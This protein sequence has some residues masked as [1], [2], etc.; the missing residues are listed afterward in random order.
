MHTDENQ[1]YLRPQ[2]KIAGVKFYS[3]GGSRGVVQRL[4]TNNVT[5]LR[6]KH[7]SDNLITHPI[8]QSNGHGKKGKLVHGM[9][10]HRMMLRT[11]N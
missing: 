3:N 10:E 6:F 1:Q 4:F 2:F 5:S 11:R 7:K 8:I 9:D